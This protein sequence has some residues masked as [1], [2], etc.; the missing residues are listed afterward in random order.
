MK[1]RI[2]SDDVVWLRAGLGGPVWR[3]G[4]QRH[5]KFRACGTSTELKP[6]R[7]PDGGAAVGLVAVLIVVRRVR[8]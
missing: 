6:M 7:I 5:A 3:L 4:S 8:K 1:N 2:L